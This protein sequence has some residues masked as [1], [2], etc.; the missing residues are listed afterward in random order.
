MSPSRGIA[1]LLTLRRNMMHVIR[2]RFVSVERPLLEDFST[3][4]Y[5]VTRLDKTHLWDLTN[6]TP[7]IRTVMATCSS[8][9]DVCSLFS[10]YRP[11]LKPC[12]LILFLS[13]IFDLTCRK[14]K[15]SSDSTCT[16]W[17]I[18]DFCV[19]DL[20]GRH[21]KVNVM[22][23]NS[24]VA[25]MYSDVLSRLNS[26]SVT[27]MLYL[28][29]LGEFIRGYQNRLLQSHSELII[30]ACAWQL[31]P[32][33]L[34][35]CVTV[36]AK[37]S[38]NVDFVKL[39][40]HVS[41][42]KLRHLDPV[43]RMV[44][45]QGLAGAKHAST[46][47]LQE[48]AKYAL[49]PKIFV[50]KDVVKLLACYAG[51]PSSCS[52][53]VLESLLDRASQLDLSSLEP[54]DLCNLI[55][56]TCK[57]SKKSEDVFKRSEPLIIQHCDS[58]P[59]RSISMLLWAQAES[60]YTSPEMLS[61]LEN[62][63]MKNSQLMSTTNVSLCIQNIAKLKDIGD[64]SCFHQHIEEEVIA[65]I[66]HFNGLDLAM[67][68]EGYAKL[69]LGS[70]TL[71][72]CIQECALKYAGD[73]PA[74]CLAKLLWAY[75]RVGGN[76]SF[77]S[78]LQFH[79]L[80]RV[81]QFTAHELCRVLWA[82]AVMKFFDVGF[83]GN[84]LSLIS[85][86]HLQ[87]NKRCSILYPALSEVIAVRKDL[88][89]ADTLRLLNHTKPMFMEEE[90]SRYYHNSGNRIVEVLSHNGIGAT[91]P[92]D[93]NGFL[94]DA[95]FEDGDKHFGVLFYGKHNTIGSARKPSGDMLIKSRYLRR[96]GI[97]LIHILREAFMEMDD[98]DAFAV[99]QR[100]MNKTP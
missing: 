52:P 77:F 76:E 31:D 9:D 80:Q 53:A 69:G 35:R 71:Y 11:Y 24:S 13:K 21:G 6:Q 63:A 4:N 10:K 92:Y 37:H 62:A 30:S 17:P 33:D 68:A 100:Q 95:Y 54:K 55:W 28:N 22:R 48:A 46:L 79:M 27:Q 47:F 66:S 56:A 86:E 3:E 45:F 61:A 7:D 39:I 85:I 74:D 67:I 65:N 98:S 44:V 72:Q 8:T 19:A 58:L 87:S 5:P 60:G 50:E 93:C 40:G 34:C 16:L 75:A 73:L 81:N 59:P 18:T 38:D 78:A 51:K 42:N 32:S 49:N 64:P 94:L 57:Y 23:L 88:V 90:M 12:D 14:S 43:Q 70:S 26:F 91:S 41:L 89:S 99:V 97:S 36:L 84:C 20:S 83:W 82:Y 25:D 29:R 2:R 15:N 96:K 1:R